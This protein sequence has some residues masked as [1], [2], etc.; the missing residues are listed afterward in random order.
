MIKDIKYFVVSL[1]RTGTTTLCKMGNIVGLNAKH[2]PHKQLSHFL[3]TNQYNFFSDTP[4]FTP[5]T[6]DIICVN[7]NY[8]SKFIFIDRDFTDIFQSWIKVN[9]FGNYLHII[10][11][12]NN[13]KDGISSSMLFDYESYVEAF[14]N[15]ILNEVNYLEI[16]NKHKK[17]VIDKILGNDKPLLVYN[18]NDGWKPFCDFIGTDI[19]NV[20]IPIL[21][22]DKMFEQI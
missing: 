13:N 11:T 4:I 19:P 5:S 18:F 17:M 15:K 16:F 21:N 22:K 10:N 14:D 12:Y 1:P 2:C 7:K 3:K 6:I 9:L 8:D 20:D